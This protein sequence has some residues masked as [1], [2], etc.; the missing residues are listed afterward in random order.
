MLVAVTDV[1]LKLNIFWNE[2]TAFR[3]CVKRRTRGN[4]QQRHA[5]NFMDRS[6]RGTQVQ[7]LA[8]SNTVGNVGQ[9]GRLR[10]LK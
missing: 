8:L 9:S 2:Y 5:R 7:R 3:D 1:S 10:I 4:D 6:R